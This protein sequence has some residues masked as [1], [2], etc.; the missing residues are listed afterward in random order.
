MSRQSCKDY[1]AA[2]RGRLLPKLLRC[3]V[4]MVCLGWLSLFKACTVDAPKKMA[5]TGSATDLYEC[6]MFK[7][8][9]NCIA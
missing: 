3:P 5:D 4:F 2:K 8:M 7:A 6:L 1:D 9:S